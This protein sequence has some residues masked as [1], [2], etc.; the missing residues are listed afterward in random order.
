[1]STAMESYLISSGGEQ[2][3]CRYRNRYRVLFKTFEWCWFYGTAQGRR[4][5]FCTEHFHH[6]FLPNSPLLCGPHPSFSSYHIHKPSGFCLLTGLGKHYVLHPEDKQ[7]R[8]ASEHAFP[9]YFPCFENLP[10]TSHAAACFLGPLFLPDL[11]I[12]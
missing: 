4:E 8:H 7:P 5:I 3:L 1:M 11:F 10:Y 9:C 12:A 2:S 6:L